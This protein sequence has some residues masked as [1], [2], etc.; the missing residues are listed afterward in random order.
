MT[1]YIVQDQKQLDDSGQLKSKF[2]FE[3]AKKF[4]ELKFVLRSGS[5][6]FNLPAAL[7]EL[8][9]VLRDI[10]DADYLLLTGNPVLLGLAVA[11]AAD[12]N[13]GNLNVLQWSGAKKTYIPVKARCIFEGDL[14]P[15]DRA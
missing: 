10:T 1:V 9:E 8:H 3:P 6:P 12:Y 4:G 14:R 7:A 5:T 13:E 2:D 15:E 11:I